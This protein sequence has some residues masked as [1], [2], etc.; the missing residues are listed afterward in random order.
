MNTDLTEQ[1]IQFVAAETGVIASRITMDS[2]IC[3]DLGVDRDDAIELLESFA[4]KFSVDFSELEYSRHFGPEA[5]CNPIFTLMSLITGYGRKEP[6]TISQ[7]IDASKKG[8]W[9]YS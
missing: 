3:E 5:G 1:V 9:R 7:L 8:S 6:L 2:R 4:V